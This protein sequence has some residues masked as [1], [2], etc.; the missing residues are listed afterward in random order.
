MAWTPWVRKARRLRRYALEDLSLGRY[1][2]AAFNAHQAV[3]LAI[4]GML[5]KLGGA[6]PMTHSIR[7]LLSA[8]SAL[9]GAEPGHN[10]VRC[11]AELE[12]HYVGARYPDARLAEY[13]AWEA[14]EAVKC[15]EV[16]LRYVESVPGVGGIGEGEEDGL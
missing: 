7:E 1:E 3:E 2:E 16:V 15:M 4:K 13:E 5:I 8:L 11:A 14:E 6:K 9:T 10:V 12:R